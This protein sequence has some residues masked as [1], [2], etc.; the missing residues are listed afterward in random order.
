MKDVIFSWAEDAD[1]KLVH[2]DSVS[3]GILCN[4]IC[5]NCKE[6]LI[7][8]HG[9]IR[10]HGFAHQSHKRKANLKMCYEVTLFKLAEQILINSKLIYTPSYYRIFNEKKYVFERVSLNYDYRRRDNQPNLMCETKSGV[11]LLIELKCSNNIMYE[12][13]I[14]L[15]N[16]LRIRIN[17]QGQTLDSLERFLLESYD[18][19]EWINNPIYFENILETYKDKGKAIRIVAEDDCR[20]CS[21]IYNCHSA[22][23]KSTGNQIMILNNGLYYRICKLEVH[24]NPCSLLKNTKTQI[25]KNENFNIEE[26][27]KLFNS[28]QF[29]MK[30]VHETTVN[31][32]LQKEE[33]LLKEKSVL[34]SETRSCF[35]CRSNLEYKTRIDGLAHCGKYDVLGIAEKTNPNIATEC[36]GY[37]DMRTKLK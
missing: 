33:S 34:T 36:Q 7:A 22:K 2:I 29:K 25:N 27:E 17:L 9:D 6:R 28:Y 12:N 10:E 37:R 20:K 21:S 18:N 8:R 15:N 24:D 1:G 35:N 4:C 16:I 13:E 30:Q 19:R 31:Y 26:F 14:D 3:N 23:D 32:V 11:K 5:P